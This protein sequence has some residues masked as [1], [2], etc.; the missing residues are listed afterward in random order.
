ML[1]IRHLTLWTIGIIVVVIL[2]LDILFAWIGG[3]RSTIS[4]VFLDFEGVRPYAAPLLAYAANLLVWHCCAPSF[5]T[6]ARWWAIVRG[7]VVLLPVAYLFICIARSTPETDDGVLRNIYKHEYG[8][9]LIIIVGSIL[10]A[11]AGRYGVPQ[12]IIA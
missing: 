4:R 2:G 10:G 6:E 5:T 11:V 9:A 8:L 1:D 3:E 12:H 7:V